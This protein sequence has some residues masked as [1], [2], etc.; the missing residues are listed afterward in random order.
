[1]RII[2]RRLQ[3]SS[4]VLQ[5]FPPSRC[6]ES[7]ERR[8]A[9]VIN[10]GCS[11]S[12]THVADSLFPAGEFSIPPPKFF[13]HFRQQAAL[14]LFHSILPVRFPKLSAKQNIDLLA[15]TQRTFNLKRL[16]QQM[17]GPDRTVVDAGC[18]SATATW[19]CPKPFAGPTGVTSQSPSR[20][21]T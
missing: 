19:P 15:R 8:A 1:M 20:R 21:L 5:T 6:L 16:I 13:Q 18:G 10:S 2:S 14:G 12:S 17:A 11:T 9:S 4:F 3:K 7:P